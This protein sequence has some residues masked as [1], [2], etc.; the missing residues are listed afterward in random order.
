MGERG[1]ENVFLELGFEDHPPVMIIIILET[2]S[3]SKNCLIPFLSLFFHSGATDF[4]PPVC[5]LV[6]TISETFSV[7][8]YG[9]FEDCKLGKFS[10]VIGK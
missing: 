5:R 7:L 4:P 9:L 6:V 10:F 8:A 3:R 2:G 1:R